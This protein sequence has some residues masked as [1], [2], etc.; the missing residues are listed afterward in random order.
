MS[1]EIDAIRAKNQIGI[2]EI[3]DKLKLFDACLITPSSYIWN[4]SMGKYKISG[5]ERKIE[6][7]RRGTKKDISTS[8]FNNLYWYHNGNSNMA[9]KA[10]DPI[11]Y[12]DAL[13]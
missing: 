2:E 8:S 11:C 3:K 7:T 12:N 1:R 10:K 13:S 4:E 6:D 5:D 9:R